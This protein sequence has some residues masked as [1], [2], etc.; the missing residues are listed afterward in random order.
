MT[1]HQKPQ[2]PHQRRLEY[3]RNYQRSRGYHHQ[4]K[5]QA[6]R[7]AWYHQQPQEYRDR[8]TQTGLPRKYSKTQVIRR[9][10]PYR[11]L[12]EMTSAVRNGLILAESLPLQVQP[13]IPPS[14]GRGSKN[15]HRLQWGESL[16]QMGRRLGITR[17]AVRQRI[18][19]YGTPETPPPHDRS[20][21]QDHDMIRTRLLTRWGFTSLE[22]LAQ[23][24]DKA[25]LA[26]W[27]MSPRKLERLRQQFPVRKTG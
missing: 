17:E 15:R 26:L 13:M 25:L 9:L 18:L 4:K 2:D 19:R 8:F 6:K 22:Q 21:A 24:S 23:Q 20:R 7:R 5:Q 1:E 12:G 27:R 16:A 14:A 10:T 11:T 3:Y